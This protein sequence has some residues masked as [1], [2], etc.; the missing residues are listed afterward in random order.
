MSLGEGCHHSR[1]RAKPALAWSVASYR[2]Y[3]LAG[4]AKA[5]GS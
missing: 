5:L 1:R 3:L 2:S 4:E